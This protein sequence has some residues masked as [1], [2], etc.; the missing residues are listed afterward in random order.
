MGP[1]KC[2]RKNG[3]GREGCEGKVGRGHS[4]IGKVYMKMDVFTIHGIYL[5]GFA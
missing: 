4:S 3:R 1:E 5:A 2:V